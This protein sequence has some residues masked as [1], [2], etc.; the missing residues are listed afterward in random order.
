MRCTRRRKWAHVGRNT[1]DFAEGFLTAMLAPA[2]T[3]LSMLGR[4]G[5]ER[6]WRGDSRA[7]SIPK[8]RGPY[9]G[10]IGNDRRMR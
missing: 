6:L 4:R 7:A 1:A 10:F 2:F 8:S 3:G 9:R 5:C